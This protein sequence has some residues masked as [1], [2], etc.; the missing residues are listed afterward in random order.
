MPKV[1]I[2][3]DSLVMRTYL[4]TT[5]Q[6]AGF[7]TELA[8][9][10]KACLDKISQFKPDVITLDI[11]MPVMDGLTC[12]GKIMLKH[13]TPVV[14]VSAI[15]KKDATATLQALELGAVDFVAK[16]GVALSSSSSSAGIL[17]EKVRSAVNCP[18]NKIRER[19]KQR[20]KHKINN[21]A[22]IALKKGTLTKTPIKSL[23]KTPI[24]NS[25]HK[26]SWTNRPELIVIGVSTGG[27]ACLQDIFTHLPK[28]FSVPIVV[29]QHMPAR[30]TEVFAQR[31]NT[32]CQ[33]NVMEVNKRI[34]LEQ[35]NIY[36]AKG[37]TDIEISRN[38]GALH[39]SSVERD[40]NLLWH[41]SVTRLVNS[42]LNSVN[43][44]RLMCVQL[45][46]MGND[47]AHAMLNAH[48]QGAYCIAES[49]DT[50]VVF[51]M[52]RALIELGGANETLPND[53]IA[54]M[55]MRKTIC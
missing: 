20:I 13:P 46:G 42:A 41:P 33:L 27:P 18:T 38:N 43:A 35:G 28:D 22:H 26:S 31:L 8:S 51:G 10:G 23:N 36:I 47:G 37:D 9:N 30:F 17:V 50:C 15:T 2:V 7:D 5:L 3:D 25:K 19:T 48:S 1:L 6:K 11:N 44:N 40:N 21:S 34:Q 4:Q 45:T 16:D 29:A 14:M 52:P 12:L 55:L 49:Q 32:L 53:A 39:A 24:S 54:D